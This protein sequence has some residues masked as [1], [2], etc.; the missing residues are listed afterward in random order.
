MQD[1]R[2]RSDTCFSEI[3]CFFE[4]R[5]EVAHGTRDHR[6]IDAKYYSSAERE[7]AEEL[8]TAKILALVRQGHIRAT[9]RMSETKKG[10]ARRWEVQQYKQHSKV[11]T[12]I[13]RDFW[14]TAV[15]PKYHFFNT[16]R[17]E[18]KEYTDILLVFEDCVAQLAAD[19]SAHD[20]DVRIEESET[21]SD[22]PTPYIVQNLEPLPTD[23]GHPRGLVSSARDCWSER[24]SRYRRIS[25]VLCP[26]SHLAFG[27][28]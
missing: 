1:D 15:F 14:R 27:R 9:G 5:D 18:G 4:V 2:Q 3:D 21:A 8:A 28:E 17:I 26:A 16:A 7:Y 10:P 20:D 24:I 25:S 19:V 23:Q 11:R 22:Y 13:D 12:Y 6:R